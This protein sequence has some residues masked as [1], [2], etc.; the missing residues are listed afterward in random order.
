MRNL[1]VKIGG[2]EIERLRR[3]Y[4][5]GKLSQSRGMAKKRFPQTPTPRQ[6]A[7]LIRQGKLQNA[8]FAMAVLVQGIRKDQPLLLRWDASFPSLYQI[9]R[10]GLLTTPIAYATAQMAALFV[11]HLPRDLAG[12]YPPE[13]LP[14]RIVRAILADTRSRGIILQQ[15]TTRLKPAEDEEF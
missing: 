6:V 5:Q 14:S 10:R 2:D 11:K 9:R 7:R 4:R 3:W 1:D 8:R 15:K 12:V 13:A